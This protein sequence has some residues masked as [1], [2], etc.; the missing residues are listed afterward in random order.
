MSFFGLFES[1]EERQERDLRTQAI[2]S[3][4]IYFTDAVDF[5]YK[6]LNGEIYSW[7]TDVRDFN[8]AYNETLYSLR[9]SA[10]NCGADCLIDV[11]FNISSNSNI[12]NASSCGSIFVI[13]ATGIAVKRINNI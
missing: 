10:Y 12:L 7:H 5:N 6:I 9:K 13:H 11:K 2:N 1:K 8:K 3:L 4:H